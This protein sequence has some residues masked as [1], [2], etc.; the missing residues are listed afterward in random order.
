MTKNHATPP[1]KLTWLACIALGCQTLICLVALLSGVYEYQLL[2]SFEADRFEDLIQ[3]VRD[4]EAT[5]RRQVMIGFV[6]FVSFAFSSVIFGIWFGKT[7]SYTRALAKHKARFSPVLCSFSWFVPVAQAVLPFLCLR[8][9]WQLLGV[10]SE[11]I[12]RF[13]PWLIA[14]W[15]LCFLAFLGL[16][17]MSIQA[18]E[19][20]D[21]VQALL[22][23]NSISQ[24]SDFLGVLLAVL[25]I[26]VILIFLKA[27]SMRSP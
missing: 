2:E 1:Q 6:Q 8:E 25:S 14:L 18:S 19:L 20:A 16:K 22:R 10:S 15:W 7:S 4:I 17:Y 26:F 24:A 9:S 3:A 5:D 23:A 11:K 27:F 21:D 13:G 12:R